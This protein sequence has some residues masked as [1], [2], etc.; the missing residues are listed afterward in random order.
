MWRAVLDFL[1][2]PLCLCRGERLERGERLVCEC[3]WDL[4]RR[5]DRRSASPE[6]PGGEGTP[7]ATGVYARSANVW[8][9]TLGEILHRFKYGGFPSLGERLA[10]SLAG[11][12]AS[13]PVL[14]DAELLVPVPLTRVRRAER[15]FNQSAVLAQHLSRLIGLPVVERAVSR[16]GR[17]RSQTKLS[18]LERRKN[19]RGVFRVRDP[20]AVRGRHVLIVDDVLTTGATAEELAGALRTAGA[21]AVSAVA[22]ARASGRPFSS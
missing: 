10:R 9:E 18:P 2:P 4:A 16:A 7:P 13:D 17:S 1:Y 20:G 6:S 21:R 14:G 19:V 3:C 15:G 12:I 8:N 11:T 22:V 5:E